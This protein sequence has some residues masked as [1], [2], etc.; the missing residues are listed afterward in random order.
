MPVSINARF[1]KQVLTG[2]QRF[3]TEVARVFADDPE[4]RSQEI[5]P[6]RGSA[7]LWGHA[8]EQFVLPQSVGSTV[9]FSPANTGPLAVSRQLVVIHD[10]AVWDHPQGFT[11]KF[12]SLYQ[13]LL[14][15]LAR[16]CRIATV[17]E[18]SRQRLAHY[19]QLPEDSIAVFGNAVGS[20]FQPAPYR[21]DATRPYLLCVGS[22]DPRKNFGRLIEAWNLVC[23]RGAIR[24]DIELRIVGAGNPLTF[25]SL[26]LPAQSER[27][28]WLGSVNDAELVALYQNAQ[29][30]VFPSLYE[31][32]GI[33]PLEAM[34]CGCP[35]VMSN[36]TS[37]PEVGGD[38]FDLD[39]SQ[40]NGAALYF[41]PNNV[42]EM[43]FQI[44]RLLL[45]DEA[46]TARLKSNARQR[47]D[48]FSWQKV[49]G[50]VWQT[51]QKEFG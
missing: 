6:S 37:L 29:A 13:W 26:G 49:A 25:K 41:N 48:N 44:E 21:T 15:R 39:D 50:K 19:L 1:R 10:A 7:G 33:P 34:A 14:P 45:L 16:R 3:A 12:R 8:W 20:L 36:V 17:S 27:V 9:L 2:V 5:L 24:E 23:R 30:F 46:Q 31:G 4:I 32:F 38:P 47:A 43:S 18:F 51:M 35:L 42:E 40:S 22:L 11:R 28:Q